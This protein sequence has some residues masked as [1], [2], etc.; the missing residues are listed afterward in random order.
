MNNSV[1]F[2][3]RAD[4]ALFSEPHTRMGG[5]KSSYLLPT[6]GALQG[7]LKSVYWKP[8]FIWVIDSVRIMSPIKTQ[9]VSTTPLKADGSHTLSTYTYLRDVEYRVRAHIEWNYNRPEF[10]QDRDM[11]KHL[12]IAKRMIAAGGRRDV[13]LGTRE[14]MA[15][16]FPCEYDDG[17]SRFGFD[18]TVPMGRMFHSYT[19]PDEATDD[20]GKGKVT[21]SFWNV[22]VQNNEIVFPRAEECDRYEVRKMAQKKFATLEREVPVVALR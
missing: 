21:K 18:G 11:G 6:Y 7:A 2:G 5:E 12:A 15:E 4:Y 10:A 13:Y 17:V 14:C 8:T 20:F 9:S 3:I 1:E 19:Y 22:T 16:V